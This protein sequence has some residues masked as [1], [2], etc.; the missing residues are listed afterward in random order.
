M[1]A[2]TDSSNHNFGELN[3]IDSK[4]LE[5]QIIPSLLPKESEYVERKVNSLIKSNN[6]NFRDH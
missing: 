3:E 1:N 6:F 5:Q 4:L 2:T